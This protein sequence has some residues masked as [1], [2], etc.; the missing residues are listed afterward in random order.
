MHDK[1]IKLIPVYAQ[2]FEA[3]GYVESSRHLYIK[4]AEG[5]VLCYTG[6]PRFRYQGLEAAPLKDEYFKNFIKSVYVSK[7]A[8]LPKQV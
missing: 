7:P 2:H 1:F 3:I 5:K 8:E 4:L 6:V